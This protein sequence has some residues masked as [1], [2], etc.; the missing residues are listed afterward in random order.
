[1]QRPENPRDSHLC[2]KFL[3]DSVVCSAIRRMYFI[4]RNLTPP[5]TAYIRYKEAEHA[6]QAME[7][8]NGYV[9]A[10]RTVCFIVFLLSTQD[11]LHYRAHKSHVAHLSPLS[12]NVLDQGWTCD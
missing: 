1:M 3:Y 10:N 8:M 11:P 12:L 6:K 4:L 7:R 2:S 5:V 9:L